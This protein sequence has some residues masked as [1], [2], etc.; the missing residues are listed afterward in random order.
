MLDPKQ[1]RQTKSPCDDNKTM[2]DI[3]E[4]EISVPMENKTKE[5]KTTTNLSEI[6]QI[7]FKKYIMKPAEIK[8]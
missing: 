2:Q 3:P 5:N 4:A 8:Q 1:Q 6:F 7:F